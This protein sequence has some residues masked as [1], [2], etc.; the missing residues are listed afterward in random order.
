MLRRAPVPAVQAAATLPGPRGFYFFKPGRGIRLCPF[1]GSTLLIA[2]K[3][4]E[5][6]QHVAEGLGHKRP[7]QC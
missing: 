5:A 3:R 2:G 7:Q 6:G 4:W 1:V